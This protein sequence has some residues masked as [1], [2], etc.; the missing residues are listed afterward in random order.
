VL[1]PD[2][3]WAEQLLEE[4]DQQEKLAAE[5]KA[6]QEKAAAAAEKQRQDDLRSRDFDDIGFTPD[7]KAGLI[8]RI[9]PEPLELRIAD[10]TQLWINIALGSCAVFLTLILC[11]Q[12]FAF[13]FD[14]LSRS[15]RWRGVSQSICAVAGC[16]LPEKFNI[17]DIS[18]KHLT[19]K[20]HDLYDQSLVVDSILTNHADIGQPFPMIELFFTDT[21][22]KV[23]AARK[24]SPEEYL[25]GELSQTV[26]M[27][28][29]QPIH[30]ALEIQDPG[31]QA[32]GYF[33]QLRY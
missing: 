5:A 28:S 1:G 11:I 27:P 16:T 24:F 26:M 23:V 32:S 29:Q 33:I 19:V 15:A 20:S 3:D 10:H 12:L 31:T 17:N 25:R 9:T 6:Q 22:Q 7:D 21:Q 2:E 30:I 18:A 13:Q 14:D 8:G 4:E